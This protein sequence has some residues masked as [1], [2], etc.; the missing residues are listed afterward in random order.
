M[1]QKSRIRCQMLASKHQCQWVYIGITTAPTL[2]GFDRDRCGAVS[3]ATGD[4]TDSL[5]SISAREGGAAGTGCAVV[6]IEGG[7]RCETT[8]A[9]AGQCQT[10]KEPLYLIYLRRDD[11]ATGPAVAPCRRL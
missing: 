2:M 11:I 1:R 10:H 3:R 7:A 5:R 8:E 6:E 9:P 4:F